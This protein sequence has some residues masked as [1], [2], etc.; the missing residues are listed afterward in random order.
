MYDVR[1]AKFGLMDLKTRRLRGDLIQYY[2]IQNGMDKVEWTFFR[3]NVVTH[4]HNLRAHKEKITKERT[5]NTTR[6]HFF[7]NRVSK[8]W[9]QL[10]YNV[11]V[12][13]NMNSFKAKLD[14]WLFGRIEAEKV[15]AL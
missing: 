1:L 5:K 11:V 14:K 7:G 8:V 13:K 6:H 12:A 2:K 3:P 9:N 10:P 4:D 15:L